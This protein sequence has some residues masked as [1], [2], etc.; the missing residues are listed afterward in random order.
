[1]SKKKSSKQQEVITYGPKDVKPGEHIFGIA[2]IYASFND[3][4][5]V[6]PGAF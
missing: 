5:V 6:G 3:T 1:M 4:F 2:H